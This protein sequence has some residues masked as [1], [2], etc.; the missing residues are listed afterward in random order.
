MFEDLVHFKESFQVVLVHFRFEKFFYLTKF[1]VFLRCW[2][3]LFG[4]AEQVQCLISIQLLIGF[5]VHRVMN[6]FGES[7]FEGSTGQVESDCIYE[8]FH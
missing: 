8:E 3:L 4:C 6:D 7:F 5:Y 2:L 1:E